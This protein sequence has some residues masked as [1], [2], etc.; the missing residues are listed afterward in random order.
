MA[1]EIVDI[2]LEHADFPY[3][4]LPEGTSEYVR[5]WIS[6][7]SIFPQASPTQKESLHQIK[8]RFH[9]KLDSWRWKLPLTGSDF[10]PYPLVVSDIFCTSQS[11]LMH[12]RVLLMLYLHV[13]VCWWNH[14][15]TS[16]YWWFLCPLLSANSTLRGDMTHLHRKVLRAQ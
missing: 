4:E 15:L 10:D 7:D 11:L 8:K 14:V 16:I 5:I 13:C 3:V 1:I 12:L 2:P 6:V 9:P